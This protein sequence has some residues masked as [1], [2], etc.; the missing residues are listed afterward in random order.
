MGCDH[1]Q[2]V[3]R[4]SHILGN[5]FCCPA[6]RKRAPFAGLIN[7][8]TDRKTI[9]NW[10]CTPEYH[11]LGCLL[12]ETKWSNQIETVWLWW[13]S[14]DHRVMCPYL[15]W[16]PFQCPTLCNPMDC[17]PPGSPVPG[18][19]QA[20]TLE[21]EAM[22]ISNAWKWKV[23][24]KFLSHGWFSDPMDCS[25]PGSSIHGICQASVLEW[26]AIAFSEIR[27]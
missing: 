21:W 5:K 3:G 22:S 14:H 2:A 19:L 15:C 11:V 17:S 1:P 13:V 26:G 7:H 9:R 8:G 4:L 23:K 6:P 20:R 27:D 18:I 12:P 10:D 24:V 25:L 16:A